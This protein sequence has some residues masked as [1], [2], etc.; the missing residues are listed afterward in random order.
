[1]CVLLRNRWS[2]SE[3]PS[4]IPITQ[5]EFLP[6]TNDD[7]FFAAHMTSTAER[8]CLENYVHGDLL[9][10]YHARYLTLE[11]LPQWRT[12]LD[13]CIHRY[14]HKFIPFLNF[15]STSDSSTWALIMVLLFN[16]LSRYSLAN[17]PFTGFIEQYIIVRYFGDSMR[18]IMEHLVFTGWMLDV[19]MF[20]NP[21]LPPSSISCRWYSL[22][23]VQK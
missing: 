11:P 12:L 16:L 22:P 8:Y 4:C 18:F 13:H 9:S 5:N 21:F 20:L 1:M 3:V 2:M 15:P 19:F 10:C 6:C 14:Y 7:C 17:S 23:R